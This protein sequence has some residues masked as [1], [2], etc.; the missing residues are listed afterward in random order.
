MVGRRIGL[1]ILFVGDSGVGK[2]TI[3]NRLIQKGDGNVTS[4]IGVDISSFKIDLSNISL[5]FTIFDIGG[6]KHYSSVRSAYYSN[7]QLIVFVFD[8]TNNTTLLNLLNWLNELNASGNV[9]LEATPIVI[10]GNKIDLKKEVNKK[11]ILYVVN[12]L[13]K[14]GLVIRD[15]IFISA[16]A[17]TNLDKLYQVIVRESVR[18]LVEKIRMK[19][20]AFSPL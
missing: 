7:P 3:K 13:K 14:R 6:Q 15:I 19:K 18:S 4:T 12:S 17:G 20:Y 9:D 1:K 2:T 8:V 16:V 10:V 11:T 5:V